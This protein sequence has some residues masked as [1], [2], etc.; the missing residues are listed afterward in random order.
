MIKDNTI[1]CGDC[2]EGLKEMP[3][4]CVDLVLTDPPYNTTQLD[5]ENDLFLSD[6]FLKELKRI[7]KNG[8]MVCFSKQ[9]FTSLV[10]MQKIFRYRYELIW[11]KT[12]P[13]RFL[14]SGWRPL[15]NHENILIFFDEK[16][17]YNPQMEQGNKYYKTMS[18][19][20]TKIYGTHKAYE[21]VSSGERF[22]KSIIKSSNASHL[23]RFHPTEKPTDLMQWLIKTYSNK[24]DLILDCF[25]GSGSTLV[26]C[27]ELHRRFIGIE[28]SEKYCEIARERLKQKPLF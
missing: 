12:L 13:T 23:N 22:P 11:E 24:N 6:K 26:A 3:D 18:K 20:S 4:K 16:A 17:T 19:A 28:I 1:I 2:L 15:D 10:V 8:F 9:P 27:Q 5:F 7:S 14:D 25:A 21:T